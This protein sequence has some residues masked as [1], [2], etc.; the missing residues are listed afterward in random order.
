MDKDMELNLEESSNVY[1][2]GNP[3]F[4]EGKALENASLYRQEQIEKLQK[5]RAVLVSSEE[6]KQGHTDSVGRN[7]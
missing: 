5:E 7:R 2:T 3:M 6:Y 1:G 4:D